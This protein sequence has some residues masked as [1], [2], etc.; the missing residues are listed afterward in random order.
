MSATDAESA[1]RFDRG[2]IRLRGYLTGF[3]DAGLERALRHFR[4]AARMSPKNANYW[5]GLGF[6]LDLQDE[7][8][9]AL[10]AMRRAH[11]LEPA[12]EEAEVFVLTLLAQTGQETEAL[13]GI[14]ELA[15]RSGVDIQLLR[16]DLAAA[17][18]RDDALTLLYNGFL[19]PRNFVRSRLEDAMDRVER[20]DASKGKLVEADPDDCRDRL[21]A[22]EREVE[23]GRVPSSL[24]HLIPW[25]LRL[26]VGDDPCRAMLVEGLTAE[27][28]EEVILDF[29]GFA[30]SVHTWLDSF[31]AGS[32]PP[33][34]A[35]FMYALLAVEEMDSNH[36]P[37]DP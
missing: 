1:A 12:D 8:A 35:A 6:A 31:D 14:A 9:A 15:A 4:I 17:G 33:E 22:L 37:P 32:M 25:V 2:L 21:T 5:V 30:A 36:L 26:G 23:A 13:S 29:R 16:R 7:S 19:H 20:F 27:E 3:D 28:R 18:M 11:Q 10:A 24:R 34:A